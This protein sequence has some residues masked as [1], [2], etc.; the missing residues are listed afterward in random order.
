[1]P[2]NSRADY[3]FTVESIRANA[4][5]RSGVYGLYSPSQWIFIGEA[6]DIQAR[7]LAHYRGDDTG[8][9]YHVPTGFKFELKMKDSTKNKSKPVLDRVTMSFE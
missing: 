1:M 5:A 2:W 6:Q 3:A 8:V 4:P 9:G 7:L